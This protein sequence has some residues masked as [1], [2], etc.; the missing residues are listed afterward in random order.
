MSA[1][2]LGRL[3]ALRAT[4]PFCHSGKA[5]SLDWGRR[6]NHQS[7]DPE[8]SRCPLRRTVPSSEEN[9]T[10]VIFQK[11]RGSHDPT[12]GRFQLGCGGSW[13]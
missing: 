5:K 3:W 10:A 11:E 6:E 12:W 2:T 1:P 8:V 13:A 7:L 4:G 9:V